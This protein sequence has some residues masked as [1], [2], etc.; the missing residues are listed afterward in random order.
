MKQGKNMK[1]NKQDLEKYSEAI[2]R[3]ARRKLI[4]W[5]NEKARRTV[6]WFMYGHK[7]LPSGK[8]SYI[9]WEVDI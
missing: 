4:Y 5:E 7:D 1:K 2:L 3:M 8:G 6:R 9:K